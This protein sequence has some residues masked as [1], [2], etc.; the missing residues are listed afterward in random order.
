MDWLTQKKMPF[1]ES[2]DCTRGDILL[3]IIAHEGSHCSAPGSEGL[4]L[5]CS[6]PQL[7]MA[8]AF[9]TQ[10]LAW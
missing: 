8:W 4:Q 10:R 1:G 7:L 5:A 3:A 2:L 9:G 6:L